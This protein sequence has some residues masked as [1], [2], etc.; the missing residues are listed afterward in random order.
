MPKND[1]H[2]G[3]YNRIETGLELY[4][5]RRDPGEEYDVIKLYPEIAEEIMKLVEIARQDMG[6]NLT[7]RKGSN[8]RENGKL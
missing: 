7:A 3:P 4:N 6:D 8:V 2:G 5:L 1:G